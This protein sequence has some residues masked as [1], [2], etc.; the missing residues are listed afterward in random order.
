[1]ERILA[2]DVGGTGIKYT[3]FDSKGNMEE[4]FSVPTPPNPK[5]KADYDKAYNDYL[6]ILSSIYK[7]QSTN[8]I[9]GIA[10]A[11][12]GV[13]KNGFI[14]YGGSL[15]YTNEKNVAADL[16]RLCDK[17]PI[18]I[19]NDAKCAV[20][21]ELA[22]GALKGVKNGACFTF[23]AAVGGGIVVNGKVLEGT[24]GEVS[25]MEDADGQVFGIT[26]SADGFIK[27]VAAAV[28]LPEN[29]G[30][31]EIFE[32]YIN[33]GKYKENPKVD[34]LF[35]A[36]TQNV[37][38]HIRNC[39]RVNQLDKVAIGGGISKQP[40]FIEKINEEMDKWYATSIDAMM[41]LEK[42]KFSIFPCEYEAEKANLRGAVA[43]FAD[44]TEASWAQK[45]VQAGR[46][47]KGCVVD[48]IRRDSK[49]GMVR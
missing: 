46:K 3:V 20:A 21:A 40:I 24:S 7:L 47:A 2:I 18:T 14:E 28:G 30:G 23:G 19:F 35:T 22:D 32:K 34:E 13:M 6:R 39:H 44:A 37:A 33:N 42:P 26:G 9:G 49:N 10:I 43:Y 11:H 41:G 29:T 8:G 31:K 38:R 25:F 27:K 5:D 17:M 15:Q 1:M 4:V 12:P 16:S 36:Y 48:S 45:I